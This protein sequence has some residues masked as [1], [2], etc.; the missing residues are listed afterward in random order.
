MCYTEKILS[1][2]LTVRNI[3]ALFCTGPV[4]GDYP[5]TLYLFNDI[6]FIILLLCFYRHHAL[7]HLQ[8]VQYG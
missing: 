7:L 1:D 6:D 5:A 8:G 4:S 2:S 3:L